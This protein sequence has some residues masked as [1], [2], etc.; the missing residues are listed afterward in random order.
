[1]YINPKRVI[2]SDQAASGSVTWSSPSNI[3]I[4]KYWGKHG[5]Q[6]PKNANISFT[7]DASYTRTTIDY[8]PRTDNHTDLLLD[9][10]FEGKPNEAFAGK[11]RQFLDSLTS[12]F[13]FL[14][15]LKL[16]INSVNS[17]PHSAGIASSASA[18]SALAL[19]LCSMEKQL[20]GDISLRDA[21]FSKKE[22]D[23]YQ[24]ASYIARLG[25]GSACRSV[26]PYMAIW[27]RTSEVKDSTD[28]WAIPYGEHIHPVFKTYK[29]AILIV[30]S[31]EKSVSSRAGHALMEHN[32]FAPVR[33]D[34]ARNRFIQ[35]LSAL[36]TGDT[37]LFG[38]IA[39]DEAL[40]LHALM[41]L[42]S[43]SYL[44]MQ[45]NTVAM[46]QKVQA[47]RKDTRLP[48]YFTLDAGPN[49]HLLYPES[50]AAETERFIKRELLPLCEA[51]RWIADKVGEGPLNI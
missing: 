49:L 14:K 9:F 47:F 1:M 16:T 8:A 44:L 18:M 50:A 34:Q 32:P 37:E 12:V 4:I 15:Q 2:I 11:I 39:E 5:L 28:D 45:P 40:S 30:A 25:S 29:D 19:C 46:I 26:Y 33:Y 23:F 10:L 36:H 24:K 3:A 43:P 7:L 27:G 22:T 48:V 20:F 21:D 6:L 35:L 17:F 13:P 41:M 42:S 38:K 51:G 31:E